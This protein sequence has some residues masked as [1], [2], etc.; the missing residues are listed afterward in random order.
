MIDLQEFIELDVPCSSYSAFV[1]E[2][3]ERGRG[4]ERPT[5]LKVAAALNEESC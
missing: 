3:G 4:R 5:F 1:R 2:S